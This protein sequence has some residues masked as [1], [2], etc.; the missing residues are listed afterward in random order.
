MK[1]AVIN[2]PNLNRLGRR[3][4]E[5][6]GNATEKDILDMLRSEFPAVG[7][8]HFQSNSEGGIIDRIQQID[9]EG[10][11]GLII[12]PGAY[13]HYSY[14]IA[15]ALLDCHGHFPIVEVHLSQIFKRDEHRHQSVTA[16]HA[17]VL[18]AG[19]GARGYILAASYI[20]GNKK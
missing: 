16:P 3:D 1:I 10:I 14:A 6:Y 7:F 5:Q 18:V 12:N 2:G 13:S 17:D 19:A 15:D 11:D 9:D 4:P 20:I 8:E